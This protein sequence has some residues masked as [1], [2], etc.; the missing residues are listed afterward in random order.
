MKTSLMKTFL[1]SVW[2][3]ITVV[4]ISTSRL[5]LS[6]GFQDPRLGP[7]LG[8]ENIILLLIMTWPCGVP[9]TIAIRKT[10]RRNRIAACI[11]TVILV[12]ISGFFVLIGGL[13]GPFGIAAYALAASVPAW[14]VL[15]I[16]TW[17][18]HYRK[19]HLDDADF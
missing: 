17:I 11:L 14:I 15:G 1:I 19:A 6:G 4:L 16:I 7:L 9:L 13:F 3:P 5:F 10:L 12:T 2:L 18:Q 8:V